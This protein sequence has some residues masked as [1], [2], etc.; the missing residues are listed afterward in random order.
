MVTLPCPPLTVLEGNGLTEGMDLLIGLDVL[1]EYGASISLRGQGTLTMDPPPTTTRASPSANNCPNSPPPRLVISLARNDL[2]DNNINNNKDAQRKVAQHVQKLPS[3]PPSSSVA[4]PP[5]HLGAAADIVP[6]DASNAEVVGT[7]SRS[8]A[9]PIRRKGRGRDEDQDLL[10]DLELL[11]QEATFSSQFSSGSDWNESDA[12]T[13]HRTTLA[14]AKTGAVIE[15]E[16]EESDDESD[17]NDYAD[18][19][20]MSGM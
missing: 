17:V 7:S 19:F 3:P 4:S 5:Q 12:T 13:S 10:A 11:E 9:V 1:D 6:R 14:T 20:D 18:D 8:R 2:G 15:E 16:E